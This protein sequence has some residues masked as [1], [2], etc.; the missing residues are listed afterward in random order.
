MLSVL[1]ELKNAAEE[2]TEARELFGSL[3]KVLVRRAADLVS[4]SSQTDTAGIGVI[5]I[6]SRLINDVFYNFAVDARFDFPAKNPILEAMV[7]HL[8][9][10]LLQ[11][12]PSG[13]RVGE[14]AFDN[15]DK[16]VGEYYR[17]V[18]DQNRKLMGE[19]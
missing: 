4:L 17:C 15:F 7:G 12:E 1:E 2:N 9:S 18:R 6:V 3:R 13:K 5:Y 14:M 19:T 16:A 10:F 11:I 8:R